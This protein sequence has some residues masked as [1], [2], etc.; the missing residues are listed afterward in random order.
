[1]QETPSACPL[2]FEPILRAKVWGGRRLETRLGKKLPPGALI[3]E[4]WE[5]ADLHASVP[6]GRSV[7]ANGPWSGRTLRSVIQ[8]HRAHVLGIAAPSSDGGFPLLLKFLD[9]RES[10]SVQV[11]PSPA[12]AA[13]HHDAHL[14]TE[15]WIVVESDPGAR[16]Y[17]GV[18]A[19]VTPP[20]F[21]S[22]IADGT[23]ADDLND[24]VVRPGDCHELP[25]G[26]CHALGAGILVAE[27][28]TPSDT[29]F[30]IYDWD[31]PDRREMHVEQAMA[32]IEFGEAAQPATPLGPAVVAGGITSRRLV[33]NDH[34]TIE[35]IETASVATFAIETS[36]LPRVWMV[37]SGSGRLEIDHGDATPIGRGSTVLI[38]AAL[39]D[40]TAVLT[41]N[42]ALLDVRVADPLEHMHA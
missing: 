41:A 14:K 13:T 32:C 6:D 23:V 1:M 30:R 12:Y 26:V 27:V 8:E 28:Q 17:K 29:T 24:F 25:S 42:T 33:S 2:L 10:L 31:R 11:H 5:L 18:R 4:S 16:I 21:E 20:T 36:G 39:T 34:F 7:I 22:H 3:G 9:A 15:A 19:E 38:P 37:L 35:R 40:A